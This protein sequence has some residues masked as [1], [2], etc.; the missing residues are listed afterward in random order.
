MNLRLPDSMRP[1]RP[2]VR[3]SD[4]AL[5]GLVGLVALVGAVAAFAVRVFERVS[6]G[7]LDFG[8]KGIPVGL[9]HLGLPGWV[10][11]LL[12]PV[13]IGLVVAAIKTL[14]PLP[15][16]Y[17]SIP[18]VIVAMA[19]RDGM[20]KPMSTF[21]KTFAAILTLGAGGSLGR[22][23]P[24]VLLGAGIGSALGR[25]FNFP[26]TRLNALVAAGAGAAIATAFHAP[27]AGAFF[28]MEIVLIQFDAQ[29]FA[30]VALACVVAVQVSG[31]LAG[32]PVF[33]IP[34]YQ[35]NSVWEIALF[36]G[37]GLAITPLARLY[38][39]LLETSERLG[40]HVK[41]PT[42]AKP[43][44][45][46][47]LFGAVA[48]ALPQT[49]GGG[50]DTIA[51]ALTGK[52]AL[53]LLVALFAAKFITIGLTNGSGWPGGV[54]APA[55]YLGAMAGGAYGAAAHA[56]IPGIV[57]QPG[58]YAIVGMASMIAGATHAPLTAMTLVLELTR[59][60]RIALPAMLACGIAAV[61]TQR[62]SPYSVDTLHLPE[63]GV[64]LPWQIH[65]LRNTRIADIMATTVH[66][67]QSDMLLRDVITLMQ[68]SRHGG[69]PVLDPEGRLV[70]MIT[71]SDIREVPLERR[72]ITRVLEVM[73]TKLETLTPSRSVADAALEMAR[74]G[75]GRIPVVAEDDPSR[76]VG[77]V[78]R[79]DVLN[80][81]PAEEENADPDRVFKGG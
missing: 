7:L 48:I 58:A 53:G 56:L 52:M 65:D 8:Y 31:L 59:D 50:Y 46:G 61:F 51:Q 22:E 34:A 3:R 39:I 26:A 27:I 5:I 19:K 66:T 76:L 37:L 6:D 72:L 49:L 68:E 21:L 36:V 47:L 14:I 29:M 70:G 24:V 32:A 17:H 4:A 18:L 13:V 38:V 60:Y 44:L 33:P 81:Y 69:Y 35:I 2:P 57:G 43:A 10:S 20:I 9:A 77:I 30:L 74:R 75:V 1:L 40:R 63:H 45:G 55:L 73:T 12:F 64:L 71:L 78:S 28:V 15:D 25:N 23:G 41:L 42:W 11:F 79:S 62:F 54:F 16:R 80:A 67:V